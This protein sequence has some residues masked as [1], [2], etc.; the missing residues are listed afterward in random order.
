[1]NGGGDDR[2]PA[3]GADPDPRSAAMSEPRSQESREP[4]AAATAHARAAAAEDTTRTRPE[5]RDATGAPTTRSDPAATGA[6]HEGAGDTTVDAEGR[7]WPVPPTAE[8]GPPRPTQISARQW[9]SVLKGTVKEFQ[10]D[11]LGDWAAALTYYGILSLFPG[12]LLLVSLLGMAGQSNS[13]ELVDNLTSVAPGPVRDLLLSAVDNLSRSRPSTSGI[14]ALVGLVGALWSASGYVGAFMRA[15]NAIYDVPEGRPIWKTLPTRVGLTVAAGL[16]MLITAL[17]VLFTG[18]LARRMGDYLGLGGGFVQVWDT[19][20]WPV[21]VIMISLLFAM[22]YWASPNARPGGF[23]WVTPGGLLAVVIW[24]AASAGFALYVANF[25]SYNKTYGSLATP[26]IFLVW[27]W[28]S[29]LAVLL[30]AEF[31]AEIQRT[32]AIDAGHPADAEP[33]VPVRDTAKL[34]EQDM[35]RDAS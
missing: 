7:T 27:L 30:G 33:Y 24:L 2:H 32:R 8:Q 3:P 11:N 12:L 18:S 17:A 4:A 1:M 23:R 35:G 29:N 5:R 6:G 14:I 10:A 34:T 16:M 25:A 19:V 13:R 9:W 15:C 21:L 31:N 22:L 20:K 26:I 28:I